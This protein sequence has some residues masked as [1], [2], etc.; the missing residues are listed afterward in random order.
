MAYIEGFLVPV[1]EGKK[2]AYLKMARDT[3]PL[4]LDLGASRIVEC[5]GDDVKRG[6]QTDFFRAVDAEEGENVVFSWIEYPD[7]AARDEA[8][9]KMETDERFVEPPEMPF[10]GK[11]MIFSGFAPMF[12]TA[13][14]LD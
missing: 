9:R 10:D 14:E 8:Y 12:D 6:K 11:R 2:D 5:W 4:F 13:G 3:A 1:P 7:K